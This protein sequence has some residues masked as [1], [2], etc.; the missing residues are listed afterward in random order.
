MT[1]SPRAVVNCDINSICQA[2]GVVPIGHLWSWSPTLFP[3]GWAAGSLSPRVLS[4]EGKESTVRSQRSESWQV[5]AIVVPESL[6]AGQRH[7]S[8]REVE[9]GE[10]AGE[11]WEP[12]TDAPTRRPNISVSWMTLESVLFTNGI[13]AL[14][15]RSL[16]KW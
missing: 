14:S 15:S 5:S 10:N 3:L 13:F 4:G 7:L 11:W 16:I 12:S 1:P 6:C 2:A 9:E 8:Q